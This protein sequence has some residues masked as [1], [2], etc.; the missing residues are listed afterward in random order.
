MLTDRLDP[1]QLV[2]KKTNARKGRHAAGTP[3][4]SPMDYLI[5]GRII[6]DREVPRVSFSTEG[7]EVGLICLSGSGTVAVNGEGH[8]LGRYDA[9]YIPHGSSVEVSTDAAVD[10]AEVASEVDG[11]YPLQVVRHSEVEKDPSLHFTTGGETSRRTLDILLGKNVQ[12]GRIVAGVTTTAPGNW[13][14]WPPH[15]HTDMLEELYVYYDMPAPSFGIQFVYTD[16][17][18]PEGVVMVRDGDA[19]AIPAGYHPN[20]AIPGHTISFL[21]AMA[22]RREKDD[23]QFGVV[24]VQ[25]GF[26][27]GGSGLEASHK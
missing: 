3:E 16:P 20:V 23:R 18:D 25:P 2:F 9:I 19:V 7:H 21:W 22:A 4:N 6:L 17:Q 26:G 5:Y 15:E 14:S 8:D 1:E 10:F 12:A 13:A 11:D 24:N 27:E